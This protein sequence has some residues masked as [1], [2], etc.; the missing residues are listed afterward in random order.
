MKTNRI[1]AALTAVVICTSGCIAGCSSSSDNE[2]TSKTSVTESSV[3][4][5]L[6][7]NESSADDEEISDVQSKNESP[8]TSEQSSAPAK[9]N[10]TPAVWQATDSRGNSVYMMG[11]I[12]VADKDAL[13]LPD[14]FEAAY[15]KCDALAVECDVS[16]ANFDLSIYSKYMY[17][18][19]TTI[20]DHVPEEQY[21]AAVRTLTEAGVYMS[22][23]DYMKPFM[24]SEYVE[25]AA[26]GEAGLSSN[27]GIDVN[28]IKRAKSDGK[29]LLEL[30]SVDF[31]LEL[32]A[33]LSDDIQAMLFEEIAYDG[34]MEDYKKLLAET[35]AEW[36]NGNDISE[37]SESPTE[38]SVD[39]ETLKLAEEYNK[40]L[41]DDR[42]VGMEEKIKSYMEDG[43]KV[44][45]LAGTAHFYGEKGIISLLENDGYTIRKLTPED[46]KDFVVS[47]Q[48]SEIEEGSVEQSAAI[49]TDPGMPRAA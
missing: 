3:T 29:E 2:Q 43:K 47:E 34:V 17:T 9:S 31:Q 23:F 27:Y 19:G 25:L 12:H 8:Q 33:N 16:S 6:S 14:Y 26:A 40:I 1:F 44:M 22:A 48:P 4:S 24:W 5:E 21:N 15:A 13:V 28:M 37:A 45:V 20:K 36:K 10:I 35:Y 11:T 32:L 30:E 42:N 18:D 7:A 49:E 39:E 46:A 41:I 38:S